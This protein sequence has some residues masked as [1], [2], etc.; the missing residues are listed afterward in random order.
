MIFYRGFVMEKNFF[1]MR[2]IESLVCKIK[3]EDN[4]DYRKIFFAATKTVIG[5]LNES[6]PE[7]FY[8]TDKSEKLLKNLRCLAHIDR[9]TDDDQ[10]YIRDIESTLK[11]LHI[12]AGTIFRRTFPGSP[13]G[14]Y[15]SLNF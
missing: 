1:L 6:N 9:P 7:N 4:I 8:I 2:R 3:K 12:P 5:E 11:E 13:A 15:H 10:V 14:H